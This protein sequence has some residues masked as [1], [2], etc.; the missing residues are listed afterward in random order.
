MALR[1]ILRVALSICPKGLVNGEALTCLT[2]RVTFTLCPT[3]RNFNGTVKVSLKLFVSSSLSEI[4][5]RKQTKKK[6]FYVQNENSPVPHCFGDSEN[7]Q[8]V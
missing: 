7:K 2:G 4:F 3:G 6:V 8:V 5:C 1:E